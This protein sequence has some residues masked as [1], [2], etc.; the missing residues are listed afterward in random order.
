VFDLASHT[1][2]RRIPL[3]LPAKGIAI[4]QDAAPL[5]FATT[6]EGDVA[7]IQPDTGEELRSAKF[8]GGGPLLIAAGQ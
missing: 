2:L 3:K 1:L 7:I 4:S 8:H 6:G 5:L